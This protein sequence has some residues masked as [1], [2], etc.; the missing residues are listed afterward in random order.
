MQDF[1]TIVVPEPSEVLTISYYHEL[2]KA[3]AD[4]RHP[5]GR[6]MSRRDVPFWMAD[7][8]F[9]D[10]SFVRKDG[11]AFE[12][13]DTAIDD[14]FNDD[15]SFRWLSDLVAFAENPPRQTP[16][17]RLAPRLILLSLAFWVA[18]PEIAAGF[19]RKQCLNMPQCG[20]WAW[21]YFER[22]EECPHDKIA[23]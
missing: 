8:L 3:V 13:T 23:A 22:C 17:A 6:R 21:R 7:Q 20:H 19:G 2:A 14:A 5:D 16:Q 10:V 11:S 9:S 1:R 18:Y 15:G 12:V 4:L